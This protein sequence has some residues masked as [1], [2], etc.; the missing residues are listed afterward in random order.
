MVRVRHGLDVHLRPR[1]SRPCASEESR[2]YAALHRGQGGRPGNAAGGH[3]RPVRRACSVRQVAQ[4]DLRRGTGQAAPLRAA[5][6][7]CAAKPKALAA[8]RRK[9]AARDRASGPQ[10]GAVQVARP[11]YRLLDALGAGF[12]VGALE[13]FPRAAGATAAGLVPPRRGQRHP[14]SRGILASAALLRLITLSARGFAKTRP[15]RVFCWLRGQRPDALRG[16]I[17]ALVVREVTSIGK[18]RGNPM[19]SFISIAGSLLISSPVLWQGQPCEELK[20]E[21]DAKIKNNGVPAFTTTIVDKDVAEDGKVVG[22]CDGGSKKI[23]Y[24]RGEAS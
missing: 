16:S 4:A 20:G 6:R 5:R 7:A 18:E 10:Q 24:K 3:D 14:A 11:A 8:P 1:S 19:K 22:T 13:R 9:V 21:I 15:R 17:S 2:A 12:A 23:V